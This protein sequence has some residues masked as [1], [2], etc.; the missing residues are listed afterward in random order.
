MAAAPFT[1]S[2][3]TRPGPGRVAPAHPAPSYEN[4]ALAQAKNS[5]RKEKTMFE[6]VR[7]VLKGAR[8]AGDIP[9]YAFYLLHKSF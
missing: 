1:H 4:T 8:F 2:P 7:D 6:I 9:G 3:T 5:T